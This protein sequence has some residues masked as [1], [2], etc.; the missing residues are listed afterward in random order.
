MNKSYDVSMSQFIAFPSAQPNANFDDVK[1][2]E[3][4]DLW[5]HRSQVT[6]IDVRRPDERQ[7]GFIPNSLHI[8]LDTLPDQ[9]DKIPKDQ[10]LVFVCGLG[11]RSSRAATWALS[12]GFESVYNLK[13]GMKLWQERNM[14]SA[15]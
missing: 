14:E 12:E 1:D 15:K 7:A 3:P 10:S 2:I 13:G 4:Q 5:E 8:V 9:M 6:I 11:T